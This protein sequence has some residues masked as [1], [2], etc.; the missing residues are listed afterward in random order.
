MIPTII[1]PVLNRYDLLDRCIASIGEVER[2]IV[3]DNGDRLDD[4]TLRFWKYDGHLVDADVRILPMPSNLGVASSWNLGVK[5][6]PHSDGWLLLNSDAY[7]AEDSYAQLEEEVRRDAMV[8]A[9][10]PPWCCAWIGADVVKRVGVFCERYYPAYMEDLDYERRAMIAGVDVIRSD[11]KVE[12]DNS[13][14]IAADARI[15]E[16]NRQTHANNRAFYDHRWATVG[17]DGWPADAEWSLRTR[18]ENSW[19]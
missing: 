3:I 1:I 9:G 13:S 10:N 8:L 17:A 4:E 2:V 19:E 12:H 6:T 15:A 7:F 11:A 18:L 16:R 14:T 5:M